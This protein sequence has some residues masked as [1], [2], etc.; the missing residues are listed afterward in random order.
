[1]VIYYFVT[2]SNSGDTKTLTPIAVTDTVKTDTTKKDTAIQ[3]L[4]ID[5]SLLK[6]K[7]SSTF[8]IVI[9]EYTSQT[10]IQKAFDKLTAYGHKL[11]M[12]TV[13]STKYQL[14]MPFTSAISDTLRAKDSLKRFFGGAPYVK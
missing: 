1:M 3:A 5:S 13:D 12:I 7:D 8:K 14:A 9:K 2:N 10:E 11:V 4:A 6:P